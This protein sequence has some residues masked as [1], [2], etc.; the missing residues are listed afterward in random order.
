MMLYGFN[1]FGF[2]IV[3]SCIFF[4]ISPF[5]FYYCEKDFNPKV[6]L[7]TSF[8]HFLKTSFHVP[9]RVYRSASF[10]NVQPTTSIYFAKQAH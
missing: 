2:V 8:R 5:I 7:P 6:I 9:S 3:V 4:Q 1:S 10:S